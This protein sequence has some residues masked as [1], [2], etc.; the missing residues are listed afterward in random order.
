MESRGPYRS[1]GV[2]VYYTT[3]R[4]EGY[5]RPM[6]PPEL[7]VNIGDKSEKRFVLFIMGNADLP[8]GASAALPAKDSAGRLVTSKRS[9]S[10][11]QVVPSRQEVDR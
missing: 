4:K 5:G 2:V 10:S 8:L 3:L 6:T 7:R 9:L 11:R 1:R